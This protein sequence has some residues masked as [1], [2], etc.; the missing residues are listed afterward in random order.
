MNLLH[1]EQIKSDV[2]LRATRLIKTD[3]RMMCEVEF[4]MDLGIDKLTPNLLF[5]TRNRLTPQ[6]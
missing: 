5:W 2:A 4:R 1:N 6:R 3:I